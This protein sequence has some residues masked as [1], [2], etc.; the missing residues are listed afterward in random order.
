V[1]LA[2]IILKKLK[3]DEKKNKQAFFKATLMEELPLP[4]HLNIIL[5]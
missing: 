5:I 3:E 1:V 4:L 2:A